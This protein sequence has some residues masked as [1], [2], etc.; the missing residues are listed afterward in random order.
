MKK[1][2]LVELQRRC[3]RV[4][5]RRGNSE[6]DAEDFAQF[7]VEKWLS[8]RKATVDQLYTDFLR[9]TYGDSRLP[10]GR[11]RSVARLTESSV[12]DFQI[13]GDRF[14][15]FPDSKT[16]VRDGIRFLGGESKID[17]ACYLLF[18][19]WDFSAEEVGALFGFTA[20]AVH[21]RIGVIQKRLK[22]RIAKEQKS[23][24]S[25]RKNI[26]KAG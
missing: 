22:K 4:A 11:A 17:R 5:K 15:D 23:V 24:N 21:Q 12:C 20:K 8:G 14:A 2:V 19:M 3:K 13:A 26:S 7:S 6:E 9:Q 16:H 1:E 18:Y 10:G 25:D